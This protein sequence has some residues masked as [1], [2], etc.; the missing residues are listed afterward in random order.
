MF[1]CIVGFVLCKYQTLRRVLLGVCLIVGDIETS[2]M[3][4]SR[5]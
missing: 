2:T 5:P 1:V 3:R 4:K